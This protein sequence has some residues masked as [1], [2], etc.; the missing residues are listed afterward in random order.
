MSE[1]LKTIK[2]DII[3]NMKARESF[4]VQTLK[5]V[6]SIISNVEI[7]LRAKGEELTDEAVIKV[8]QTE[9]KKRVENVKLYTENDKPDLAENEQKEIDIIEKYLPE[10]MS[11]EDITTIVNEVLAA[12]ETKDFGSVMKEVMAK[13]AGN[14]D[15]KTVT[16]IVKKLLA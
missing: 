8:L 13:T 12:V 16:E 9:K 4:V 10:Q 1:L 11:E 3:T 14:A 15:G 7:D 6:S 5:F 2:S